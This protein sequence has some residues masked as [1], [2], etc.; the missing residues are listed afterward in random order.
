MRAGMTRR[1]SILALALA[2]VGCGDENDLPENPPYAVPGMAVTQPAP[3]QPMPG[4]LAMGGA[5]PTFDP[6]LAVPGQPSPIPPPPPPPMPPGM[7][8]GQV[9]PGMQPGQMQ[10]QPGQMQPAAPLTLATGF[11][12]DPAIARGMASAMMPVSALSPI[13]SPLSPDA[14]CTGHV[15]SQP[16]HVMTLTSSFTNLRILVSS[17]EDVVLVVRQPDGTFRCDDDTDPGVIKNPTMEGAFS[18]GTY[19]IWVGMWDP[20]TPPAPYVIGFTELPHVT[21]AT[22]GS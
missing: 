19:T 16:A 11:V 22:L 20:A 12:P 13:M 6:A 4:A 9:P 7:Q 3:G 17:A 18:P 2:L 15:P 21:H 14:T 10:M 1:I 8:P 5:P